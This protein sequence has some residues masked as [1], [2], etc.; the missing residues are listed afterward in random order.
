MRN[1]ASALLLALAASFTMEPSQ[2]AQAQSWEGKWTHIG[3]VNYPH[4]LTCSRIWRCDLTES[5]MYDN[6]NYTLQRTANQT[7]W[8]PLTASANSPIPNICHAQAPSISCKFW[9]VK[10]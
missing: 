3:G 7:T 9:L 6:Q 5:I 4:T 2:P 1:K 8:G 10:K